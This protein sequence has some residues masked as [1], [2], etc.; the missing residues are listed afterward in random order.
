MK[1]AT[2]RSSSSKRPRRVLV[3]MAWHEVD[4]LVGIAR[5][6]REKGWILQSVSPGQEH[7][8]KPGEV[9][10]VICQLYPT[11]REHT[12]RVTALRVPKVELSCYGPPARLP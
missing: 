7:M 3:A 11:F 2:S 1:R 5:Y 4:H 8:L 10:G 6:A 12:R 9:D